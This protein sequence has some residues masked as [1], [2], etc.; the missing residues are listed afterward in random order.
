M[1][2]FF[3]SF[4]TVM[5]TAVCLVG[6]EPKEAD[7]DRVQEITLSKPFDLAVGATRTIIAKVLPE[8][9][10]DKTIQ[11]TTSD[12]NIA[13]VD[14]DGV[15]TGVATGQVVITATAVN[16]VKGTCEVTVVESKIFLEALKFNQDTIVLDMGLTP[17]YDFAKEIKMF[18]ENA[19]ANTTIEWFVTR[20]TSSIEI[21]KATGM[22]KIIKSTDR[23]Y[24][25][26]VAVAGSVTDTCYVEVNDIT[27]PVTGDFYYSDGTFSSELNLKKTCIGIVF[28]S[29]NTSVDDEILEKSLVVGFDITEGLDWSL[30]ATITNANNS[31]YGW[32][33]VDK[34]KAIDNTLTNYPA[35]KWCD[36]KPGSWYLPSDKELY[37]LFYAK[38]YV[39]EA[40]QMLIDAKLLTSDQVVMIGDHKEQVSTVLAYWTSTEGNDPKYV[41]YLEKQAMF[42]RLEKFSSWYTDK[43]KS[44]TGDMKIYVRAI[45]AF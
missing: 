12:L 21:D 5:F 17:T 42:F 34:L 8:T 23:Q 38:A 11:W 4:L 13:T 6:C 18:P 15:V 1:K 30:D 44:T 31:V 40:M 20:Y 39:N 45:M 14:N 7:G 41:E 19:N 16:G 26:I 3:Y 2:T 35:A 22:A 28:C 29:K 27:S 24:A 25:E 33:N 37:R 43:T 10:L 32:K 9:A 36:D